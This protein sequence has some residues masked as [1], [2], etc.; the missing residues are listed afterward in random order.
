VKDILE[1]VGEIMNEVTYKR[2]VCQ[3]DEL[4]NYEYLKNNKEQVKKK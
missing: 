2:I 1:F 4:K 3:E